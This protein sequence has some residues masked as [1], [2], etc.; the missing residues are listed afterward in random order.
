MEE[1]WCG[2]PSTASAAKEQDRIRVQTWRDGQQGTAGLEEGRRGLAAPQEELYSGTLCTAGSGQGQIAA[3]IEEKQRK[4]QRSLV[5]GSSVCVW[6]GGPLCL[7]V[8]G[9]RQPG[10]GAETSERQ[11][12]KSMVLPVMR[13]QKSCEGGYLMCH[14]P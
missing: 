10:A 3:V 7:P 2:S 1:E 14:F 4:G 13:Q 11:A 5:P 8:C 9:W 6:A 12:Q